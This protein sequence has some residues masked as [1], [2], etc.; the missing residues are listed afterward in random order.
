VT[1]RRNVLTNRWQVPF[2][3]SSALLNLL[4]HATPGANCIWPT[5]GSENYYEHI[6]R[7]QADYE[8]IACYSDYFCD[9]SEALQN[10][11]IARTE[12]QEF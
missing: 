4:S 6:I 1:L 11:I 10:E 12:H 3:P 7:D 2:Q 9:L 5:S 8:W